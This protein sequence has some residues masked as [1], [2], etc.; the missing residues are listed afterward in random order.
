MLKQD[1]NANDKNLHFFCF[2]FIAEFVVQ[3]NDE[4]K[5][6]NTYLFLV[7][8]LIK[9]SKNLILFYLKTLV[10]IHKT[11]IN[12]R[13]PMMPQKYLFNYCIKA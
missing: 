8:V 5:Q 6:W 9:S 7:T 2:L 11:I 3:L 12:H 4:F 1:G 10:S 13:I